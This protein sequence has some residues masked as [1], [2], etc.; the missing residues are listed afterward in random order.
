MSDFKVFLMGLAL[1]CAGALAVNAYAQ[2]LVCVE[3]NGNYGFV[4]E[5]QIA[6]HM[7]T[8]EAIKREHGYSTRV[9][10]PKRKHESVC[11]RNAERN[12]QIDTDDGRGPGRVTIDEV[13]S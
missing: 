2:G 7:A 11:R 3:V 5:A 6:E 9:T 8:R 12:R 13:T 10:V 4:T 1:L